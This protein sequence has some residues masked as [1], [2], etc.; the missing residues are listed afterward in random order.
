MLSTILRGIII[1]I[2]SLAVFSAQQAYASKEDHPAV[3]RYEGATLKDTG[4]IHYKKILVPVNVVPGTEDTE[5]IEVIGKITAHGYLLEGNKSTLEVGLNYK[6]VIEKLGAEL[7]IDCVDKLCG[8]QPLDFYWQSWANYNSLVVDDND[9]DTRFLVAKR[10]TDKGD[11]YYQWI[12]T[13]V[14]DGIIGIEQTIIEPEALLLDQVSVNRNIS[15]QVEQT[16]LKAARE[17][18]EGSHDHP[19][20]SRYQGAYITDYRQREFEKVFIP[21]GVAVNQVAPVITVEGKGTTIGYNLS[22]SQSSLQ[23]YQNYLSALKAAGFDI[24]FTCNLATCGHALL[25]DLYTSDANKFRFHP[26]ETN[27]D[28]DSDFRLISAKLTTAN[29]AIFLLVAIE[30]ALTSNDINKIVVDIVEKSEMNTAKVTIDPQYLNDEITQK[31]RV[32]LHGLN[33]AFNKSQLLPSSTASLAAITEYLTLH[34]KQQFYVVGHTDNVGSYEINT[35]L[36]KARAQTVI[37]EL[38][39]LKIDK[40]RLTPIGIGPVSPKIANSSDANKAENRRVELV[41]Q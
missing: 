15:V 25:D 12:I 35:Q 22:N 39:S 20:I 14:Y 26:V 9:D 6:Q 16:V 19:V 2:S 11:I 31:G 4:V 7:L 27:N 33:F 24:L 17:D 37:E 41:L 36:S 34:P 32:V 21:T 8:Y 28:P 18:I 38:I 30:G 40:S 29:K 1:F 3:S 23:I 10:A 13:N 5:L